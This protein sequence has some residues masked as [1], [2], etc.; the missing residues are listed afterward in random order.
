MFRLVKISIYFACCAYLI[1]F[2]SHLLVTRPTKSRAL[3]CFVIDTAQRSTHIALIVC[4]STPRVCVP[5]L[6]FRVDAMVYASCP[7]RCLSSPRI[8][9]FCDLSTRSAQMPRNN[10]R[11]PA[12]TICFTVLRFRFACICASKKDQTPCRTCLRWNWCCPCRS[13]RYAPACG[14]NWSGGH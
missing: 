4:I 9:L 3:E 13:A 1:S 5:K 11:R 12:P 2:F 8:F 6:T 7:E 14:N 10:L